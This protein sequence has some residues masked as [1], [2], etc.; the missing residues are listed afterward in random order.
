MGLH[1]LP[2]PDPGPRPLN[3]STLA[4]SSSVDKAQLISFELLNH[5][6]SRDVVGCLPV[7][8]YIVIPKMIPRIVWLRER[9]QEHQ[10]TSR[11]QCCLTLNLGPVEERWYIQKTQKW[12]LCNSP[13][14]PRFFML[15]PGEILAIS[16]TQC[17]KMKFSERGRASFSAFLRTDLSIT[18]PFQEK[19]PLSIS[20]THPPTRKDSVGTRLHKDTMGPRREK[21]VEQ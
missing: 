3:R 2:C 8:G 15:Q 16:E 14:P 13:A 6:Q 7:T 5:H 18:S 20:P 12:R 21:S 10:R 9:D 1:W 4:W 19:I 11:G 17:Y